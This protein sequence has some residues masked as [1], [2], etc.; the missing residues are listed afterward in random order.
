VEPPSLLDTVQV[1]E[2]VFE[3]RLKGVSYLLFF[4]TICFMKGVAVLADAM[5]SVLSVH[6]DL[7]LVLVG[8]VGGGPDGLS[9]LQY[10]MQRAGTYAD[11]IHYLGVLPHSQLYPVVANAR[12]IVLPSLVDNL[13][14]TCL[15]A[16]A[17]GQVVIGTRGTSFEEVLEDGV[18]GVLVAPGSVSELAEAIKHVWHMDDAERQ[19]IGRAAQTRVSFLAPG[20]TC[21]RLEDY[22]QRLL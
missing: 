17:L 16:M 14:N 11:R 6:P 12:A 21:A 2:S 7:H 19:K 10:V 9:M 5:G 20:Y 1:D 8:K 22:F 15:E 13:P 4:G 18:S 3:Q